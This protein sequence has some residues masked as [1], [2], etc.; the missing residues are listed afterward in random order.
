MKKYDPDKEI[1]DLNMQT[2]YDIS[3]TFVEL[4]D[5]S[6]QAVGN[7]WFDQIKTDGIIR[8]GDPSY[9]EMELKSNLLVA[10]LGGPRKSINLPK[11]SRQI[12]SDTLMKAYRE[13]S[14]KYRN[15]PI[16]PTDD[17]CYTIKIDYGVGKDSLFA[18]ALK[19]IGLPREGNY[20]PMKTSVYLYP[21]LAIKCP[22]TI[23]YSNKDKWLQIWG[24]IET[25]IV[26]WD[27]EKLFLDTKLSKNIQYGESELAT[28]K[29]LHDF[30]NQ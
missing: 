16:F 12:F 30:L 29:E 6:F 19:S 14:E 20:F 11:N 8:F 21:G 24:E 3:P 4:A 13:F 7:W 23:I 10:I 15:I 5:E 28:P 18:P 2:L 22:N 1:I 26:S 27:G 9:K 25:E 17:L